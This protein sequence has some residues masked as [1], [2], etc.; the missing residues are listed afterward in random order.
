MVDGSWSIWEVMCSWGVAKLPCRD[1]NLRDVEMECR[2]RVGILVD[3]IEVMGLPSW[4]SA[5]GDCAF[6]W[7]GELVWANRR[8]A[9]PRSLQTT[10]YRTV[11]T[12]MLSSKIKLIQM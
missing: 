12:G 3:G 1:P 6:E 5:T 10:S 8:W 11:I 9:G 2:A 4:Y 7:C